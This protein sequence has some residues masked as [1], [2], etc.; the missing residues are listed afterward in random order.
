MKRFL[1]SCSMLLSFS[2]Q[3]PAQLK[4]PVYSKHTLANGVTVYLM[5]RKGVPLVEIDVAV[6]GGNESD[7]KNEAG[8]ADVTGDLL[9]RGSAQHSADEF[10]EAVD[11][12]GGR[13]RVH[14]DE[15]STLVESEFLAKDLSSG[16][17]LVSEALIHPTFPEA[18]VKKLIAQQVD[19]I[20]ALKDN[21]EEATASYA[22]A[23]FFGPDHPYG[24]IT[25]EASLGRIAR[26]SIAAYHQ[27]MYCGK[28]LIVAVVGDVD[29][30]Q[31]E[32]QVETAFSS[33]PPGEAY[34]WQKPIPL[35]RPVHAR[36]LLVDK[37][38]ATQT[39]FYIAQPGIDA[40][41]PDR[42]ALRLVNTLFGDRFT[43]ML[44]EEL[45]IKTGLTYGARNLIEKDR[46]QGMNAISTFTK[47][48]S[49]EQAIDLSLATLKRLN[50]TGVTASQL[51]SAR[52]Y[53]KGTVPREL[54][55]TTTQLARL[56]IRLDVEGF[57]PEEI[58]N[59]FQ[60]LD[61]VTS[62]QAD[63][64]AKRYFQ[65]DG[66]TFVLV[67]DAAKIRSSVKKYAPAIDEISITKPGFTP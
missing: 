66:L 11:A 22:H 41:S 34:V 45:R 32:K 33:L 15:Q 48:D 17:Q 2:T 9:R 43:S 29:P 27:R 47:T 51:N 24:R 19:D 12:L 53:V 40:T 62:G 7:P 49:T 21:P 50:S 30:E 16:L 35:P 46:L 38:G 65:T 31:A 54:I 6:K 18:E 59:M 57:G 37:P 14:A 5:Q 55:E 3:L 25:D 28:N 1:L 52:A 44:N 36:L 39:Y 64:A 61:A 58:D 23:F 10:A 26:E 8:L 56:L 4:L 67:G 20:K 60:R 63:S 42:T 13:F